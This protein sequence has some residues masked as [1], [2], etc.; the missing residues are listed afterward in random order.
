MFRRSA[1]AFVSPG[2]TPWPGY[3]RRLTPRAN[4]PGMVNESPDARPHRRLRPTRRGKIVLVVGLLLLGVGRRA[5]P[6]VPARIRRTAAGEGPAAQDAADPRGPPCLGGVRV[7]RPGP[8]PRVRQ[9]PEGRVHGGP[10]AARPGRG[11]PGGL[12]LPG[13]VPARRR[14]RARRSPALHG[15]HRPQAVRSRTCHG[16]IPAQQRLR[17]RHGHDRQ[18][19]PGRGRHRLR[20]GQGGPCRLQPAAQG[21]AAA[22]GLHHQLRP[23]A[24]HPG[25]DDHRHA[26]G[27][28]VQQLSGQGPAAD[29]DRQP[30]EEA[31]RAAVSPT[32][33]PWLYFVTVGP[34]DT[35]FTDDYAEQQKNVEEFNRSRGTGGSD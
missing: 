19:R 1:T 9:H 26:A 22:D 21:H 20:H 27:Q 15:R 17:L 35:R 5:D 28:P 10:E 32:P 34:G 2:P 12:P 30:G 24:L 4:V 31:L 11:Q 8:G 33:G 6:V 25:H 29:A 23:Q 18:H 3:R 13:H 16:G 14:D 7:R